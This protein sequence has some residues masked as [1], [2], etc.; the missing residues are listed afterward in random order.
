MSSISLAVLTAMMVNGSSF[1]S[2]SR[3]FTSNEQKVILESIQERNGDED[4]RK[5]LEESLNEND[6]EEGVIS[7]SINEEILRR[8]KIEQKEK[9]ELEKALKLS[10][11]D[12]S[13]I[14][15]LEDD[16]ELK[17]AIAL[18]LENNGKNQTIIIHSPQT[19]NNSRKEEVLDPKIKEWSEKVKRAL[20]EK[21][22][23]KPNGL[24]P[25][26]EKLASFFKD[27]SKFKVLSEHFLIGAFTG[28]HSTSFMVE[29]YTLG[30]VEK[31]VQEKDIMFVPVE[32]QD[33]EDFSYAITNKDGTFLGSI[34]LK[35]V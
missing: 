3:E 12:Q 8:L 24:R 15:I 13:T 33:K 26:Q 25:N 28:P 20:S 14:V 1:A 9:E 17:K 7:A 16:E 32:K 34:G 30:N 19:L 18:S 23:P 21:K 22:E 29:T 5:A 11:N 2:D 4:L 31:T 10:L 35:F 27:G 6:L